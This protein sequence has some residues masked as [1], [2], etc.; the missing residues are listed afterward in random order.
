MAVIGSSLSL[1]CGLRKGKGK[2]MSPRIAR[3]GTAALVLAL[4]LPS[5]ANAASP[6]ARSRAAAGRQMAWELKAPLPVALWG[7]AGATTDGCTFLSIGGQDGT[8]AARTT[9]SRYDLLADAWTPRA[10]M[11]EGR[12]GLTAAVVGQKVYV[13]GGYTGPDVQIGDNNYIYDAAANSWTSGAPVPLAGGV[14][15]AAEA[16]FRG[17]VYLIGGDDGDLNSNDTNLL[18]NPATD[19][20]RS[21]APMPTPRE[22]NVAVTLGGKIYVAGGLQVQVSFDGLNTFESYDPRTNTWATLAPMNSPRISPGI[23]TDGRY[24]YVF[25]GSSS[26][27]PQMDLSSAER[28][29][30]A[31]DTW[32]RAPR[33]VQAVNA[34]ASG[35]VSGGLISAGGSYLDV[36]QFLALRPNPCA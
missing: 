13:F 23:A 20:W 33:M 6:P 31:T 29:D 25:G 35:F 12:F 1:V 2:T 7:N 34:A 5:T 21:R 19:T 14:A 36:N 30:P 4:L 8:G 16:S 18:Y 28:Y 17:R 3:L 15:T 10:P 22:N 9:V 24:V 11:P 32:T 27:S 26:Y